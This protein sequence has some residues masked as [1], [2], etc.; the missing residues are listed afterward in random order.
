MDSQK[1][2]HFVTTGQSQGD[3]AATCTCEEV[4]EG[5]WIQRFAWRMVNVFAL[6]FSPNMDPHT[7]DIRRNLHPELKKVGPWPNWIRHP[8]TER[9][10]LG[11][12]PGGLAEKICGRGNDTPL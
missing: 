11:S 12:S 7:A 10:I 8:P 6:I 4:L 2:G 5:P 1:R 9:E 3:G